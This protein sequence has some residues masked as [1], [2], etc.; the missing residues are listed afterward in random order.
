MPE[1]EG[2]TKTDETLVFNK[3][4][5]FEH[6]NGASEFYLSYNFQKLYVESYEKGEAEL[7]IEVYDQGDEVNAYG[8]YSM[9]RSKNAKIE[10]IGLQGYY[11]AS[12]L[13]FT[14]GKYYI[15]MM[16]YEIENAGAG[17]LSEVANKLALTLCATPEIPSVI[18]A[19]PQENLILNS[20]QYISNN[21]MGLS[22]LGAAYRATYNS[23]E[24]DYTIFVIKRESAEEIEAIVKK[25]HE[26]S[27]TKLKKLK[28]GTYLIE[29]PFNGTINL[30]WTG[31]YLLGASGNI[32]KKQF[33]KISEQ[34]EKS[35]NV[36]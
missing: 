1:L 2:W 29:D 19:F 26:F 9:E 20:R 36:K 12:T 18:N 14:T 11:D 23:T 13:N 32:S 15:K 16:S 10:K 21:F 28:E 3:D 34:V 24:G 8:I 30:K 35:L 17:F 5:L 7:T 27:E 4:N 6:I 31:K 22:F 25:Y 33:S